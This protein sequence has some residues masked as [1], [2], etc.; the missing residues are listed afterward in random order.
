[1]SEA[2]PTTDPMEG[3]VARFKDVKKNAVPVQFIDS[4]IPGHYRNNFSII[5]STASQNPD[6][7]PALTVPQ[8]FQ[9]GMYEAPPGNGPGWHT[10]TYVELFMPLTGKWRYCY[11]TNKEDPDDIL[12]EIILEPWD[13]ITFPPLLWRRFENI[14]D[15]NALGF[16]VLDPIEPFSIEDPIW[17][18]FMVKRAAEE[19]INTDEGGR[20]IIPDGLADIE[21]RISSIISST[22]APDSRL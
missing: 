21:A 17:P 5:G 6:Y 2:A 10:H 12:G 13:V 4:V 8:K 22:R 18:N 11:G 1:M 16:A 9:I 20:M 3:H 7:R 14:S 15:T 19:G